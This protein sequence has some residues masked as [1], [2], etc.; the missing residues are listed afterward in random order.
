MKAAILFTFASLASVALSVQPDTSKSAQLEQLS[1]EVAS[2]IPMGWK[3][4]ISPTDKGKEQRNWDLDI[5]CLIVYREK[6]TLGY[7]SGLNNALSVDA[8]KPESQSVL[9]HF[10][11]LPYLSA[12]E[13]R[14]TKER[15]D[16]ERETRLRAEKKLTGIRCFHMGPHPFP[17]SAYEPQNDAERKLVREYGFV[18]ADTRLQ[19]LPEYTYRHLSFSGDMMEQTTFT[20]PDAAAE[21][22][23]VRAE[24]RRILKKYEP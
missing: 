14:S 10:L 9:F 19:S 24:L 2:V 21:I 8:P 3:V 15:N 20:E 23:S 18:W 11:S 13:Y 12:T 17:P 7:F 1:S 5:P 4:E 6:P 22:E 16:A